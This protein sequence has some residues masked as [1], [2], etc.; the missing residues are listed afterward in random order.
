MNVSTVKYFLAICEERS[1]NKA[2]AAN[3]ISQP[4]ISI[5]IQRL[6]RELGGALLNRSH[7]GVSLTELG[8]NLRPIFKRLV[9][10]ADQACL[11]AAGQRARTP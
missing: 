11:R 3:G 7:N 1:F 8:R 9:R 6:E 5:A 10:S 4:S 2:A